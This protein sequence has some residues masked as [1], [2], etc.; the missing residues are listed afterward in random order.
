M[1][2]ESYIINTRKYTAVQG[3]NRELL[4][5]KDK[6]YLFDL[7]Y[8]TVLSVEGN[9]AESFLQG[10]LTCDVRDINH[11]TMRQGALCNLKGRIQALLDIV[12]TTTYQLIL[13]TDLVSDTLAS[14]S[15]V[16]MLSRVKLQVRSDYRVYGFYHGN[17]NDELPFYTRLPKNKYDLS[18]NEECYCYCLGESYFIIVSPAANHNALTI[19]FIRNQQFWGSLAWHRL[20]I[21]QAKVEIYPN[22]RG[23]F[24]PHRLELHSQ[25][26]ISFNKGCYKGQEIIA[27][28]HYRAKLKHHLAVF[29]IH[30]NESFSAGNKLFDESGQR[31]VG[32]IVDYCPL[33][34]ES[35][36]LIAASILHDHPN[37]IIIE[38]QK[39]SIVLEKN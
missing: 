14:L 27:R 26:Y 22:T 33:S 35:K 37:K 38:G 3:L 13:A 23:L 11:N 7:S 5:N 25:G 17:K 9:Q 8:L 12:N 16:A 4:L 6:N 32:E 15:K 31:E 28:T 2:Q 1:N 34:I 29:E 39:K 18:I 10:Q 24:L 36:F 19:P 21:R 20:Q 30:T